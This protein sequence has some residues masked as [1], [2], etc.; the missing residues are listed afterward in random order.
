MYSSRCYL[1]DNCTVCYVYTHTYCIY[2]A[3]KRQLYFVHVC[4]GSS[5]RVIYLWN[6]YFYII[7]FTSHQLF[8][9]DSLLWHQKQRLVLDVG[10]YVCQSMCRSLWGKKHLLYSKHN[11]H[12]LIENTSFQNWTPTR[13]EEGEL[14]AEGEED[15][16][17]ART[18]S[19]NVICH[20]CPNPWADYEGY[21]AESNLMEAISQCYP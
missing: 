11:T 12:W 18:I 13:T 7:S 6:I 21:C 19:S 8:R 4:V 14:E 17:H 16:G 20:L 2:S 3:Y 10:V 5:P 1:D 9:E 15:T